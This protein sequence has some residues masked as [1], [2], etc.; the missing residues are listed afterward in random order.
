MARRR[1]SLRRVGARGGAG[2]R[3]GRS[4]EGRLRLLARV[5]PSGAPRTPAGVRLRLGSGVEPRA[6]RRRRAL[7]ERV[8]PRV[9]ALE[10]QADGVG[11]PVSLLG[12]DQL[13]Q[14]LL[15]GV[16]VVELV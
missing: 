15:V 6:R 16:V 1:R 12:D 2:T 13:G 11:R 9:L 7:R 5:A 8:E 4:S 14:T 10:L 3:A